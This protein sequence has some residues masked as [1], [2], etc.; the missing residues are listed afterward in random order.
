MIDLF[1][2]WIEEAKKW[3]NIKYNINPTKK[4]TSCYY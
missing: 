3:Y 4:L 2:S 1:T